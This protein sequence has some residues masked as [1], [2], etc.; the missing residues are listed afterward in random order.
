[1]LA[2]TAFGILVGLELFFIKDLYS[3]TNPPYFRANTTFKFGYHA[4][5]I[6]SIVFSISMASV[7]RLRIA[8]RAPL[9]IVCVLVVVGGAV[10]PLEAY[11]QYYASSTEPRG[12][13]AS[14][15]M[16][17]GDRDTVRY[18]NEQIHERRVIAEAVGESYS[19][20]SRITTFTGMITPMGWPS[21]EWTWRFRSGEA[22]NAPPSSVPAASWAPISIVAQN[23]GILY[24]THEPVE[25]RRL[26]DLYGIDYVYVGGLERESYPDLDE[27]KFYSIGKVVFESGESR[28]FAVGRGNPLI[29]NP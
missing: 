18:I 21:H 5:V 2:I 11:S 6:L 25:A 7:R 8:V 28:L 27:S 9:Y 20:H 26:I 24:R 4:W 15:W 3:L 12:L 14:A 29:P 19:R 10:Y 16:T 23:I 13:D 1:M 22:A 17:G